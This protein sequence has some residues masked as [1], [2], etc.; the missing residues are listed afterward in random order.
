M[1]AGAQRLSVAS[2]SGFV[3]R[4]TDSVLS[5][6]VFFREFGSLTQGNREY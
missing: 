1:W 5:E 2:L 4:D 6:W 3:A